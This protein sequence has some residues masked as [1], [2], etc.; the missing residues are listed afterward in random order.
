MSFKELCS[1][2]FAPNPY[3]LEL[4]IPSLN[5]FGNDVKAF[6]IEH[7]NGKYEILDFTRRKKYIESIPLSGAAGNKNKPEDWDIFAPI[8]IFCRGSRSNPCEKIAPY[9]VRKDGP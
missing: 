2:L 5:P 8:S 7:L 1:L 3:S 4:F 6:I 9:E